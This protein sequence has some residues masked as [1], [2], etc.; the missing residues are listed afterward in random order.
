MGQRKGVRSILK[1]KYFVLIL[2]VCAYTLLVSSLFDLNHYDK[3]ILPI[4]CG[5]IFVGTIVDIHMR[6]VI[7]NKKLDEILKHIKEINNNK[8]IDDKK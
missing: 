1:N 4:L 2:N 7:L 8:K 3:Y 6:I 5:A